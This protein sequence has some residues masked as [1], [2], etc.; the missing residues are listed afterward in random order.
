MT[1]APNHAHYDLL[2]KVLEELQSES[3][4]D[5]IEREKSAFDRI[6]APFSNSMVL[7]GAGWLGKLTLHG[8]R[9]AGLEP[10]GFSDNNSALWGKKVDGML[11][12]P[13]DEAI[14][15]YGNKACFIVTIYNGTPVRKQLKGLFCQRVIPFPCLFWKY[16]DIFVPWSGIDLPHRILDEK[17]D[18][19]K[20]YGVL[21]DDTS[22]REFCEQLR[23]RVL[24]DYACLSPY[25]NCLD[26]YFPSMI[27]P[28]DREIYVDC[29][30]F[31]GDSIRSFLSHRNSMFDHIYALEP[32]R[33]NFSSLQKYVAGLPSRIRDKITIY[34]CAAASKN[35]ITGFE[36]LD[37]AG[38]RVSQ[39]SET[40]QVDCRR[41]DNLLVDVRPTYV[42]MDI[43]GAE[44][45]AILG[46]SGLLEDAAPVVFSVCVYHR[47][48]HLW[49]IP[50]LI[51][52]MAPN[53]KMFLRRYAEECWEMVCYAV[54]SDRLLGTANCG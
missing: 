53:H 20:G 15:L 26:T 9:K 42:K 29:G 24:L 4:N 12:L 40:T 21:A 6:S 44:M 48:D 34:R 5:M 17:E 33:S 27:A 2:E 49:R 50:S 18:I 36:N 43:E 51:H 10:L 31:D 28:S 38:S 25:D 54:P 45:D 47:C 13:P 30:A 14:R 23:W 8:L 39:D 46:S 3:R 19:R 1:N 37:S 41:L 11:V 7:F 32:D 22:R 35:G 16:S 52:S